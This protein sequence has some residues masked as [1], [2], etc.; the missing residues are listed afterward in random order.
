[1]NLRRNLS[2]FVTVTFLV[3]LFSFFAPTLDASY[4]WS[5]QLTVPDHSSKYAPAVA[6]FNGQVHMVYLNSKGRN[7]SH[8]YH[9]GV[10]WSPA[11]KI[12]VLTSQAAPALAA[13]DNKLHVVFLGSRNTT[14]YHSTYNGSSWTSGSAILSHS[15]SAAP[16]LAVFGTGLH[17]IHKD[18]TSTAINHST[19]NGTSWTDLGS[20]S[21]QSTQTTPGLAVFN[22]QLHMVHNVSTS[23]NLYHSYYNGTS[24]TTQSQVLT[25]TA[26]TAPALAVYNSTLHMVTKNATTTGINYASFNGTSWS[27]LGAISNQATKDAPALIAYDVPI[28]M[29]HLGSTSG[30]IYESVYLDN[31]CLTPAYEPAYWNS[32]NDILRNNNCYNY[33]NNKRTD[34]FAQPGRDSGQMASTMSCSA[35]TTAAVNDGVAQMPVGGCSNSETQI[36]LVVAPGT[37]YHWYRKDSNGYWSHKPGGTPATNLDNSGNVITNPETADRGMYTDFCGYFCSCESDIQG[38]SNESIRAVSLEQTETPAPIKK[39]LKVT[40]MIFSGR[41]NPTFYIPFSN[42][43][44]TRPIL[45]FVDQL[46]GN[47]NFRGPSVTPSHLGYNGL[48]VE[49]I[50]NMPSFPYD[51][52]II[53][54]ENVDINPGHAER[55]QIML[56]SGRNLEDFLLHLAV[57]K[58][59]LNTETARYIH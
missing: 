46:A 37:D 13:Y 25:L 29:L 44:D 5:P 18:G 23:N 35:V 40:V 8:C 42:K 10:S 49:K 4:Y 26:A 9:D 36:A 56:D 3:T 2:L 17:L 6:V 55:K 50:G 24:W 12:S 59:V 33:G 54:K 53:Y 21:G 27:S 34:T 47:S 15:S 41:A 19:Y 39:G 30:D 43:N 1:M 28:R 32:Y 48:M 11:V 45:E 57:E 52:L 7:L 20:I 51:R 22:S 58:G 38:I 14:L 16:A 31:A